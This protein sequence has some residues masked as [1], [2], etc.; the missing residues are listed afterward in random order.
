[1]IIS[2]VTL[3]IVLTF[4]DCDD[5]HNG[6]GSHNIRMTRCWYSA[7]KSSYHTTPHHI[8]SHHT[9]PHHISSHHISSHHISSHHITAQ[10]YITSHLPPTHLLPA[11]STARIY[12]RYKPSDGPP[13]LQL[14]HDTSVFSTTPVHGRISSKLTG[15]QTRYSKEHPGSL[16]ENS[17]MDWE[18]L[19]RGVTVNTAD[20]KIA[21]RYHVSA[22][23][24]LL[25]AFPPNK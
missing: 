19:S 22:L 20:G 17:K 25:L 4:N 21:S 8:T 9:T 5:N 23:K 24:T 11:G 10:H 3:L 2:I 13:F 18:D 16:Q 6:I 12:S 1:M 15:F 14:S 7:T